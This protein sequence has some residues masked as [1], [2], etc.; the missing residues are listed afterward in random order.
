MLLL[1]KNMFQ[2]FADAPRSAGG[3]ADS[4]EVQDARFT[5]PES[6]AKG[7]LEEPQTRSL[8]ALGKKFS[9]HP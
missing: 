5:G 7:S 2:F 3:Y 1:V 4:F 8:A 9:K 6:V